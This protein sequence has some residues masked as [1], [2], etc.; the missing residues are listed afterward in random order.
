MK[1]LLDT[2][3][4]LW[5]LHGDDRLPDSTHV[6]ICDSDEV[7]VS[8]VS[9][10]EIAIKKS[11]GKLIIPEGVTDIAAACAEQAIEIL[12][13]SV[14]ALDRLSGLAQLH[15]DPFDR[16]IIT[17]ALEKG[18]TLITDDSRIRQYDVNTCW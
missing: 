8:I 12:P 7:Y 1:Y 16:I 4:L 14:F 9:L 10:W 6:L 2:H 3:T 11:I 5:F 13:V 17:T 18:M 15:G